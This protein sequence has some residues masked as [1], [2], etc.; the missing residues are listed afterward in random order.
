ML[1][2]GVGLDIGSYGMSIFTLFLG[3][4]PNYLGAA[5][6][7]FDFCEIIFYTGFESMV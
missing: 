1:D 3:V 2:P 6:T 7:T 4:V 5:F